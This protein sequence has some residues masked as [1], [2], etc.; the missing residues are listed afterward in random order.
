V[1]SDVLQKAGAPGC[2]ARCQVQ[3]H[4]LQ[5]ARCTRMCCKIHLASCQVHSNVLQD[6]STLMSCKMQVQSN[7]LQDAR[8][9]LDVL[10]DARCTP[11]CF[12]MRAL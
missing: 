4:L 6:A 9:T 7:V 12:K 8:C 2:A 11:M 3:S 10:R 1:Q 5:D